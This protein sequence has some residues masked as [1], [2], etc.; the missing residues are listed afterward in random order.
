MTY[1]KKARHLRT[2]IFET[3]MLNIG[4]CMPGCG[5]CIIVDKYGIHL[6]STQMVCKAMNA[7]IRADVRTVFLK[8]S[9][10]VISDKIRQ[11]TGD[12]TIDVD[13]CNSEDRMI[14][15]RLYTLRKEELSKVHFCL[16]YYDCRQLTYRVHNNN[17]PL[18]RDDIDE[19][20]QCIF[21]TWSEMQSA[22]I[23]YGEYLLHERV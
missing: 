22:N 3:L 14:I 8:T 13:K 23:V 19:L 5:V 10:S 12:Y 1:H 2:Q 6:L 7:S 20:T 17:F 9:K 16:F 15:E 11:P 4:G 21:K 18:N